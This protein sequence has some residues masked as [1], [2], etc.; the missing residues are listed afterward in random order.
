MESVGRKSSTVNWMHAR[1]RPAESN[2]DQGS[3]LREELSDGRRTWATCL[4]APST[5]SVHD[6]GFGSARAQDPVLLPE[7]FLESHRREPLAHFRHVLL[8][9][10]TCTAALLFDIRQTG[11]RAQL[12]EHLPTMVI[13]YL[14][15]QRFLRVDS[16]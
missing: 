14:N 16:S 6:R 4:A 2:R 9:L 5:R 10:F 15:R 8:L 3:F 13:R 7:R 11:F 12:F 1:K